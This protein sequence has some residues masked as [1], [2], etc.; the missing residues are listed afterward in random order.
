MQTKTR[1]NFHLINQNE[2]IPSSRS[3]YK[4]KEPISI[5]Y[6][7]KMI[8]KEVFWIAQAAR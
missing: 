6:F 3:I 1:Y 5:F 7:K 4:S 2:T 8:F